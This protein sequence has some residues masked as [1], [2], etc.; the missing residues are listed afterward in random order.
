MAACLIQTEASSHQR[1][2]LPFCDPASLSPSPSPPPPS[3]SHPT[4]RFLLVVV[5][6]L[7][8]SCTVGD[9]S[10]GDPAFLCVPAS[11]ESR[12]KKEGLPLP[13]VVRWL[14]NIPCSA[15]S[16]RFFNFSI[17]FSKIHEII[18]YKTTTNS[19]LLFQTREHAH[20]TSYKPGAL[21]EDS[22]LTRSDPLF[23]SPSPSLS[24]SPSRVPCGFQPCS[25]AQKDPSPLSP[26][27]GAPPT[28]RVVVRRLFLSPCL[29]AGFVI[30]AGRISSCPARNE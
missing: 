25:F 22:L 21:Q 18:S 19:S 17:H 3:P 20:I 15:L 23:L 7:Y 5:S 9:S 10:A 1:Q 4:P 24:L 12:T 30:F 28:P 13:S 8:V 11:L 14:C 6:L 26:R 29:R 27:R 16:R 2:V